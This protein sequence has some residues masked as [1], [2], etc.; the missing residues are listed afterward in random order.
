MQRRYFIIKKGLKMRISNQYNAP[1]F[2]QK[3]VI[4]CPK[5][6][7]SNDALERFQ[8]VPNIWKQRYYHIYY[9]QPQG[10]PTEKVLVATEKDK[11]SITAIYRVEGEAELS[12]IQAFVQGAVEFGEEKLAQL[13]A[14]LDPKFDYKV[15]V[16]GKG[17][18]FGEK[19]FDILSYIAFLGDARRKDLNSSSAHILT[20]KIARF[21]GPLNLTKKLKGINHNIV[22]VKSFDEISSQIAAEKER[23]CGYADEFQAKIMADLAKKES[24]KLIGSNEVVDFVNRIREIMQLPPITLESYLSTKKRLK[25]VD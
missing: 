2:K 17:A 12:A 19:D 7:Y 22:L 8:A 21:A 3:Y 10:Q 14:I 1:T 11:E 16:A 9:V 18:K 15:K 23:H 4:P 25:I 6:V 13:R 20:N 24:T 5:G